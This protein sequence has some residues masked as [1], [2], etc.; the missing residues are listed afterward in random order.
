MRRLTQEEF[1]ARSVAKHGDKY[2]Y[3]KVVYVKNSEKVCIICKECE[4]EFWQTPNQH[5]Q[6]NGCPYCRGKHVWDKRGR[7]TNEEFIRRAREIHW[8]KYEYD[9]VEYKNMKTKVLIYCKTCQ[10]YFEQTPEHHLLQKNGCPYCQNKNVT[11]E[12]FIRK[13]RLVHGDAYDYSPTV[14]VLSNLP[15]KIRCKSCGKIFEQNPNEHLG[16][17]GCWECGIKRQFEKL[18]SNTDEFIKKARAVHGDRYGYDKVDYVDNHTPVLIYCDKHGYFKQTP[19]SHLA[20]K[21]CK[22]CA[23]ESNVEC[24]RLPQEEIIRRFR[25]VHGDR[26][27]YDKVDYQGYDVPVVIHCDKHGDFLQ[28]PNNHLHGKGC[29]M[30]KNSMGEERVFVFLKKHD[31]EFIPQYRVP[32]EYLFCINKTLHLDFYL[33]QF[34]IVIEFNGKQH[35]EEDTFF[36]RHENGRGFEHQQMRDNAVRAYCEEHKLRLIE[37][38][39]TEINN[40]EEI[41]KKELKIK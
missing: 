10:K 26:Y 6:G 35:Y 20:G 39:Y 36:H 15:V 24:Q 7:I 37:I 14:Y 12:E 28:S 11:T 29:P 40:I 23:T 19:Q 5:M 30:C 13:A 1:V 27:G 3:S 21:G 25:E 17:H 33:P 4:R 9:K 8:D 38:P 2:D 31:I 18:R 22:K 16:G 34:N 32:N 41:L